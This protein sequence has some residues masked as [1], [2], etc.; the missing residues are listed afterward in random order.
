M[1]EWFKKIGQAE[2]RNILAILIVAGSFFSLHL[3]MVREIPK[4]NK[5]TVNQAIGFILGGSL[6]GV[7]GYFFGASKKE[8]KPHE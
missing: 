3:M 4:E 5:D 1:K 6:A 8:T 2:I 7:I